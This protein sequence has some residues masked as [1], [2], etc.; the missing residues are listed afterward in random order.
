[1]VK[2]RAITLV[3]EPAE[4]IFT[5]GCG[6]EE[7]RKHLHLHWSKRPYEGAHRTPLFV[8]AA[9]LELVIWLM[10]AEPR[11]LNQI[12]WGRLKMLPHAWPVLQYSP[13]LTQEV[14]SG[15]SN[16][17]TSAHYSPDVVW[18]HLRFCCLSAFHWRAFCWVSLCNNRGWPVGM[19]RRNTGA[20]LKLRKTPAQGSRSWLD[21]ISKEM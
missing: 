10:I 16:E 19:G 4:Y 1:M 9:W 13:R 2:I 20:R 17:T 15:K 21:I 8:L 5:N 6:K 14:V 11:T 18:N 7:R 3:S 12:W